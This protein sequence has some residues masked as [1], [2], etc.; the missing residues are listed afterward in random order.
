MAMWMVSLGRHGEGDDL[1][2]RSGV[3]GIGWAEAGDLTGLTTYA[4]TL[5]PV[6]CEVPPGP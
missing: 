6:G 4:K 3:V 2:L 5:A 1:A